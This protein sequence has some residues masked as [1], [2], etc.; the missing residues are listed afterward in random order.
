[1]GGPINRRPAMPFNPQMM[2]GNQPQR[3]LSTRE[4]IVQQRD[5]A[6][7]AVEKFNKLIELMDEHPEIEEFARIAEEN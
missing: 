5:S 2:V 6:V 7:R 3:K 4:R 1:M